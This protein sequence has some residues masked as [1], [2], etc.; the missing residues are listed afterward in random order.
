M[1][2]R[3]LPRCASGRSRLDRVRPLESLRSSWGLVFHSFQRG[4]L[5]RLMMIWLLGL[6]VMGAAMDA[7]AQDKKKTEAKKKPNVFTE[8]ADAPIDY[9]IQGEYANDKDQ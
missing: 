3:S 5:M 7:A 2:A 9:Q 4:D 8:V 1:H 6:F